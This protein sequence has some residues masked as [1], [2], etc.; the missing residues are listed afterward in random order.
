[1]RNKIE[2][3]DKTL[4]DTHLS[5]Y[6]RDSFFFFTSFYPLNIHIYSQ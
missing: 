4:I 3:G 1:M 2:K 5:L 6:F